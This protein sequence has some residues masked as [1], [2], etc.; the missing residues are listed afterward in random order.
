[1][2]IQPKTIT[3]TQYTIV[4]TD[5]EAGEFLVDPSAL[6]AKVR[7]VRNAQSVGKHGPSNFKMGKALKMGKATKD[8][9]PAPKALI[10]TERATCPKCGESFLTRGLKKHLNSCKGTGTA[11]S[12]E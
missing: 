11:G 3:T 6:Q 7:A 10:N 4:I 9:K 1:M 8:D 5:A 12:A 2:E